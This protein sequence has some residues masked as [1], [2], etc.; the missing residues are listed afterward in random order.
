[1][2]PNS[3]IADILDQIAA[4]LAG[5]GAN[6]F[7]Q[8]A[9]RRAAKTVVELDDDVGELVQRA[10]HEGLVALPGIGP[11]IA[12]TIEEILRTGRS[13]LLERLRGE[14][15][16][17]RLFQTVPGIGPKFAERIHDT[18]HIDTLEALEIAAHDGRLDAVPGVGSRRAAMVRASLAEMLKR[19]RPRPRPATAT[20]PPIDALLDVDREYRE[21]AAAGQLRTIAPRRFNPSAEAW[22]PILHTNRG[23]WHFTVLFS[24]TARAHD[25]GRTHDW[26]VVY[27][28]SDD[29]AEGQRTIV[30]ETRGVL[31]GERVVRGRE[32]ECRRYYAQAPPPK[33][34]N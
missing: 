3:H 33:T 23:R 13:S 24:N 8:N 19:A 9:Y 2:S 16:P 5:Q 32:G 27:F 7:R 1:M 18:L 11:S 28:H 26:V 14:S 21:K 17:E 20:E 29:H 6:P 30:T 34:M 10:G 4:L 22:L 12:N 15:R 25:L 31:V